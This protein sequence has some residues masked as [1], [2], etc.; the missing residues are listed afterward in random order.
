MRQV[1]LSVTKV[2]DGIWLL[3]YD[4]AMALRRTAGEK[5]KQ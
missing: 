4:F 1:S 5:Q 2:I 3:A